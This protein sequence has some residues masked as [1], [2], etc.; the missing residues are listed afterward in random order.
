MFLADTNIFL[1]I[2]L[3]QEKASLCQSFLDRHLNEITI[4]D[5]SLHLIGVVLLQLKKQAFLKEIYNDLFNAGIQ[6]LSLPKSSLILIGDI[7]H[8]L[9]LDVD[10]TY[11]YL[12]AKEFGLTLLMLD[13]N[14]KSV[15]ISI[16]HP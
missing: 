3:Q 13:Q 12:V 14:F 4:S 2:L 1:E 8:Q 7:S 16:I 11:Q 10:D 5:F 15:D 9:N 6:I